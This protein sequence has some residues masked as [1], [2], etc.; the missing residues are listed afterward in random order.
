[1]VLAHKERNAAGVPFKNHWNA[2]HVEDIW[3]G[4]PVFELLHKLGARVGIHEGFYYSHKMKSC[5]MFSCLT[6]LM[7][8]KNRQD[9][10]KAA[11]DPEYN[12]AMRQMCKLGSNSLYGKMIE[13][14]HLTL[15]RET[16]AEEFDEVLAEIET[17]E[18][19]YEKINTLD[20]VGRM[21]FA[22]FRFKKDA[23]RKLAGQRPIGVGMFILE[24]ARCYM[25]EHAYAVL[26]LDKL[27]Y[28]DT[29]CFKFLRRDFPVVQTYMGDR[30]IPHWAEVEESE[31]AFAT[32]RMWQAHGKQ[33]GS[34]ED[35]LPEGNT[36]IALVAKK[37]YAVLKGDEVARDGDDPQGSLLLGAKGV[38]MNDVILTQLQVLTLEGIEDGYERLRA[39]QQIYEEEGAPRIRTHG[40]MFF[41][42]LLVNRQAFVLTNGLRRVSSNLKKGVL[43]ED[44]AG[45]NAMFGQL[46]NMY[47][48]KAFRP[49]GIPLS[50]EDEHREMEL[51]LMEDL[52]DVELEA[53]YY[54]PDVYL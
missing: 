23:P 15:K 12:P 14:L 34:F 50:A 20:V 49:K 2:T 26:G 25:Y 17:G 22:E 54:G 38:R 37:F 18:G 36:G 48:M 21:V 8:E 13:G 7:R 35:E 5:E 1:M 10:L 33:Y 11:R 46:M 51:L 30:L 41:K 43:P 9:R 40:K 29:D 53:G 39:Y 4:T 31:P 27:L 19:K 24:Y 28:T 16:T 45:H 47:M 44:E 6:E 42:E 32:Q 52:G 3:I